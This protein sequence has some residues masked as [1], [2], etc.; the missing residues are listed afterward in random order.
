MIRSQAS[1]ISKPPPMATPFTAA[2]TGLVEVEAAES[3]RRSPRP[4]SRAGRR[5]PGTFRSLPAENARS[6]APVTIAT[7]WPS[8]AAKSLKISSSS[9]WASEC[10]AFITSGRFRV[11]MVT[12][13]S[14]ST[15]AYW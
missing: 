9:K 11:T 2:I 3:A 1:A 15:A 7:H 8:S 6:P 4:A 5:S 14:F 12:G 10:S 13:P